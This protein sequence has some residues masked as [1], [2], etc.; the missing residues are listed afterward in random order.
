M[1]RHGF[2]D[3]TQPPS[4]GSDAKGHYTRPRGSAVSQLRLHPDE[5]LH[6]R[7]E[8]Y[9]RWNLGPFLVGES[10][11][12]KVTFEAQYLDCILQCSRRD[13]PTDFHERSGYNLS[14]DRQYDSRRRRGDGTVADCTICRL[15]DVG[16][17]RAEATVWLP[18]NRD[19]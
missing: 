17:H 3:R 16:L 5:V 13:R 8:L 4:I 18:E 12:N 7:L 14:V 11:P 2:P 19:N 10:L 9:L 15:V 1:G 6:S